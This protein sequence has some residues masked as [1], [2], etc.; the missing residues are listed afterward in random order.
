MTKVKFVSNWTNSE[1]LHDRVRRNWEIPSF[2]EL[3]R[4]DYDYLVI[5]N[6][7]HKIKETKYH[8][9]IGFILEPTWSPYYNK[10]LRNYCRYV[11]TSK[12][13]LNF[14]NVIDCQP[15]QFSHDSTSNSFSWEKLLK[16]DSFNK[17]HKMSIVV[18]N[19]NWGDKNHNYFRREELVRKIL[20]SDLD[21]HIY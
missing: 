13:N 6:S 12:K 8:K 7:Y 18:S 16:N 1:S 19:W 4:E 20:A 5:F 9:N 10:E 14:D 17:K 2:V 15:L 11:F 3:V 21:I